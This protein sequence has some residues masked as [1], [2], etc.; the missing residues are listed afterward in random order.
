M[1][2]KKIST[3]SLK[4]VLREII[5]PRKL[6]LLFGLVLIIVNRLSGLV[7]PGSTKYLIDEVIV[8]IHPVILGQGIKI[9]EGGDFD[10]KLERVEVEELD[11]GLVQVR[12]KVMK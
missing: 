12:Y 5:L 11:E 8:S 1:E 4:Y 7:L 3:N 2:K 10:E 9:F 6:L